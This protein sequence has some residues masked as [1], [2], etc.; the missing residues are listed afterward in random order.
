M[1]QQPATFAGWT[2]AQSRAHA[3]TNVTTEQN[4]MTEFERDLFH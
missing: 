1:G 2:C 3:T 4:T